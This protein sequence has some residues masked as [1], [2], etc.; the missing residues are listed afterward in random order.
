MQ[1]IRHVI[2]QAYLYPS[3]YI[4]FY[5]LVAPA[6]LQQLKA[7]FNFG[8]GLVGQDQAETPSVNLALGIF[9]SGETDI[10][11]LRLGIED[12]KFLIDV[13]GT[14][15]DAYA[16]FD[17]LVAQ[18]AR[19]AGVPADKFSNPIILAEDSEIIARLD[20]SADRLL[21]PELAQFASRDL[22]GR[23]TS[24]IA[25]SSVKLGQVAFV[26]QYHPPDLA[27]DDKRVSL[28]RK[29]FTLGPRPGYPLEDR[30]FYSKAPVDSN[31]HVALLTSLNDMLSA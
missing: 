15:Q 27:L 3:D 25:S 20:F 17:A 23:T 2:H 28:A 31:T 16:V 5:K 21:S 18:V 4:P 24:H 30:T 12:R 22:S 9:R 26:V 19:L 10:P 11:V 14:S 13:E 6:N 29:E 1:I 7:L 8:Q